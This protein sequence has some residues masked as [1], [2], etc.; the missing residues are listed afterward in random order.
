MLFKE[1]VR[2]SKTKTHCKNDCENSYPPGKKT[3][4]QIALLL[5]RRIK[6]HGHQCIMFKTL[7]R[8]YKSYIVMKTQLISMKRMHTRNHDIRLITSRSDMS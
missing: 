8:I 1:I 4:L 5:P 2:T 3:F 7:L 6:I